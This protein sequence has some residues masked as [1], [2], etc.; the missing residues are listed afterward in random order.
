MFGKLNQFRSDRRKELSI[1][2]AL[3]EWEQRDYSEQSPQFLKERMFL[4][5]GLEGAQ[6]VETGTYLGK[7]TQFLASK[8]PF[9]HSIEPEAS[10]YQKAADKFAG[11]NV[12]VHNGT[13]EEILPGLLP[14]LSGDINFWLDGHYSAGITYRG[15]QDCPVLDE[16]AA[17][18]SNMT[19]FRAVAILIDDVRCFL[20]ENFEMYGYPDISRLVDWANENQFFW[21]IE[22]DI[23]IMR[24]RPISIR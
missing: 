10:L 22:H 16:L 23:F 21:R 24:R 4:K 8:F 15:A 1:L 18:S 11:R 17:I 6:W 20:P 12:Q 19:N 7:T 14:K 13:S 5:H 9:V 3:K 2:R